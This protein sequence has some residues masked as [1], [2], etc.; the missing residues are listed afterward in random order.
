[1]L[2]CCFTNHLTK[3]DFL[4][5][6]SLGD[7]CWNFNWEGGIFWRYISEALVS[8]KHRDLKVKVFL[9]L[10]PIMRTWCKICKILGNKFCSD[11]P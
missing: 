7:Q 9:K 2:S 8:D 5:H 4:F 11:D 3:S 10:Q 1:M 6:N